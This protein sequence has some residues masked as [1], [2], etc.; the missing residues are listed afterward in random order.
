M[1]IIPQKE[2]FCWTD[3]EDLGDLERLQVVF[4][5][6]P[7]EPL[8][9]R[10]EEERANGR[11]DYPIRRLWNSLLAAVVFQHP[12]IEALRRELR[13]NAQ[14][15]LICG[16]SAAEGTRTVPPAWVYSRFINK[17]CEQESLEEMRGIF[18]ALVNRCLQL[19]PEFGKH[20]GGDGKAIASFARR[21]GSR[22]GDRRGEHDADW[23]VHEHHVDNESGTRETVAKKWFGFTLHLLADTHYEL[24]VNFAVTPASRNEMPVMHE[25]IDA[26]AE[27]TPQILEQAQVFSGDRGLDDG[28]LVSKLWDVHRIKPVIDIRN[29][30]KDGEQTK[31]VPGTENVLYDYRGTVTCVCPHTDTERH[32]PFGGFEA[33]RQTLKYRCP[34]EHYGLHCAGADQCPIGQAVRIPLTVDRRVFTPVARSSYRWKTLYRERTAVERINSC[35]DRSFGF[36]LHTTRGLAKMTM[37]MTMALS[38]MLAMAVGRA[39]ENR[40]ELMRTLVRTSA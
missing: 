21:H 10:L 2:F 4:N 18:Q 5:T 1:A 26:S 11:N 35:L 20:L 27:R 39:E 33:D 14:L 19:F 17:L 32:M 7:D 3:I 23:G 15:R 9:R 8:V 6:L 31:L 12:S 30:W 37:R 24:P 28:K 36:E 34:A 25:L 13:R 22:D 40:D 29:L 38:V 16:F